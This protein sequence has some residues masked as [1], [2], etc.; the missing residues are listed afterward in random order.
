MTKAQTHD[1]RSHV[2][3]RI[4]PFC[5]YLGLCFSFKTNKLP[6]MKN[7]RRLLR[8]LRVPFQSC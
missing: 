3:D 2:K 7:F 8:Q 1:L 6:E 5:K 4:T